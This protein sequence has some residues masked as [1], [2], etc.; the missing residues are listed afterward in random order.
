[1]TFPSLLVILG[2]PDY[3]DKDFVQPISK[4]RRVKTVYI[5]PYYK[6]KPDGIKNPT[7]KQMPNFDF[8]L[9]EVKYF[10][11]KSHYN[12]NNFKFESMVRPVCLPKKQDWKAKFFNQVST[13]SGYGRVEAIKVSGKNQT[14]WQ[15][16][17]AYLRI[18]EPGGFSDHDEKCKKVK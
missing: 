4:T 14:A 6:G 3:T 11:F 16:M 10:I 5:H 17:Q 18:I 8:A 1:M 2:Q 7:K 15:L 12:H 9:L 13:V